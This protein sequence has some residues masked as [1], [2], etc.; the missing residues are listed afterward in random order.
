MVSLPDEPGLYKFA[1]GPI[2][3]NLNF[4]TRGDEGDDETQP[5]VLEMIAE[6]KQKMQVAMVTIREDQAGIMDHLW[7]SMMCLSSAACSVNAR[8]QGM[9]DV[10]GDTEAVLDVHNL[11]D[12]SKRLMMAIARFDESEILNIQDKG[13]RGSQA[14]GAFLV[15]QGKQP[16]A[17]HYAQERDQ[18]HR[19]LFT[20]DNDDRQ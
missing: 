15:G 20:N 6:L 9:E 14:G 19:D 4:G 1:D 12:L 11:G 8:M 18:C 13:G 7:G 5:T 10:V 2:F 16:S 3:G 17:S